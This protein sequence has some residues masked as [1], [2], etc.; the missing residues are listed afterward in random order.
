MGL[1]I[2][3]SPRLPHQSPPPCG[4]LARADKWWPAVPWPVVL[5]AMAESPCFTRMW[6]NV[7]LDIYILGDWKQRACH[8]NTHRFAHIFP[9]FQRKKITSSGE[10]FALRV[11]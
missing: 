6:C 2:H 8:V 4:A 1:R 7:L 5:A 10:P 9:C 3:R 11:P